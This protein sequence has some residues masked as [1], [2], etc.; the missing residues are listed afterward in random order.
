MAKKISIIIPALNEEEHI[1]NC[2]KSVI[3]QD[4]SLLEEIIVADG[5]S[6]DNTVPIALKFNAKIVPGGLPGIGRNNG[7]KNAKGDYFLF[8]DADTIL[9]PQF[10]NKALDYF[11]SKKLNV[12]SFYLAPS[13][14]GFFSRITLRAYNLLSALMALLPVG[15]LTAGCCILVIR[16]AHISVEGFSNS[17]VVLE[18][19]DYIQR[20]KKTGRF[21]VIPL[22]VTTSIRRFQ[23]GKGIH[24]T[25]A[26]FF[27]YFQWII[28]GKVKSDRFRYWM[29]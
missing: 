10:F 7:A 6:T 20:I 1:A 28:T 23:D 9:P 29:R 16:S 15:F 11:E 21:R 14:G 17:T 25:M 18:E 8:L 12:A 13:Q 24:Q 19:Y 2:L 4:E 27:Y 26:L 5:G 3:Q 22:K